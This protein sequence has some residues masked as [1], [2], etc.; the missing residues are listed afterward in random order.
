MS[1]AGV[2]QRVYMDVLDN[3]CSFGRFRFGGP[4]LLPIGHPSDYNVNQSRHLIGQRL[5]SR[6]TN[7]LAVAPPKYN[8]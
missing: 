2:T 6:Q 1:G 5:Q 7:N 8:S 4:I 3:T